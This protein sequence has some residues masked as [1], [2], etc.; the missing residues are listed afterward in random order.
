MSHIKHTGKNQQSLKALNSPRIVSNETK[1]WTK[2]GKQRIRLNFMLRLQVWN[3]VRNS[4]GTNLASSH[5]YLTTVLQQ[6][7]INVG[8]NTSNCSRKFL[9]MNTL[10]ASHTSYSKQTG[11]IGISSGMK[12]KSDRLH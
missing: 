1:Y 5:P 7:Y 10:T 3:A 8:R 11:Q 2:N 4:T 9:E 6:E 12:A